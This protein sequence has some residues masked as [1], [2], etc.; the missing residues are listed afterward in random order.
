MRKKKR[1]V[2]QLNLFADITETLLLGRLVA[3]NA[4]FVGEIFEV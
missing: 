2:T 1:Q 4:C 3:S